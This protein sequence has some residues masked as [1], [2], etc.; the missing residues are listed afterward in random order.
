MNSSYVTAV[1]NDYGFD[2][3]YSRMI[4]AAGRKSDMLIAISTSGNS[5]NVIN[6]L[7]KA[8]E[9]GMITVG[10]SGKKLSKMDS[11]CDIMIKVPSDNTARIQE[12]HIMIGHIVCE[13]IEEHLF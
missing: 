10:L 1:A 12:S 11:I 6:A 8:K 4:E 2:N 7:T 5:K 13:L 9:V 3:I